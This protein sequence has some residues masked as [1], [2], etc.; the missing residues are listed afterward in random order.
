MKKTLYFHF[1]IGY[2]LFAALSFFTL[3]F[4][5]S[6]LTYSH[7]V[8]RQAKIL[9]DTANI[10]SYQ[11][12][13]YELD[14][15]LQFSKMNS[16]IIP[17]SRTLD[18]QI[19][20][21][22]KDGKILF[23]SSKYF[24]PDNTI[25]EFDPAYF[26]NKYYK[27]GTFFDYFNHDVLSV[28][29]PITDAYRTIGYSV[30]H[31]SLD[32]IN[33]E[34]ESIMRIFYIIFGIVFTLSLILLLIFKIFVFKPI[35]KISIA[36]GEYAKGNFTYSGL[37]LK[38]E[39][40]IGRLAASLNYMAIELDTFEKNQK[41]FIAN[42]SHD[43]RSPLTSIKGYMEAMKDGTIPS[44][45]QEKYFDTILFETERLNKL[46]SSLLTLNDWDNKANR[47]NLE[48]FNIN[49]VI[50][51]TIQVFEGTCSKRKIAF[52]LFFGDISYMVNADLEKIQ[53]VLYNLI[54]NALK[55]SHNDSEI[56]ISVYDKY[57][58]VFVSIKDF[59]VGIPKENINQIW[60]RFFKT[61]SS[62][63]KDKTGSGL[64][65]S[66]TKEIIQSHHENINVISTEGVGSEFIF[67]LQKAKRRA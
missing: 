4:L 25:Q 21:M 61:D 32:V 30:V 41:K 48:N 19:W 28:S 59:G 35:K 27:V 18:A 2:V 67:T 31:I 51:M 60:D 46:T 17:M 64:G 22:K 23:D 43:F 49:Q 65:L 38:S 11:Y 62:R 52:N 1:I 37:T 20:I 5:A 24:V 58:K 36:A 15:D 33:H 54:D 13:L 50:K 66:I 42:I 45:M 40:E 12:E 47:L 9:Y 57:D 29:V 34:L 26:G 55:F 39:D 14:T 16:L 3:Y 53:Q 63:G 7:L 8:K 44:E 6:H 10:V 56:N